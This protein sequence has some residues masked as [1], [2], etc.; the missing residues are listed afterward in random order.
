MANRRSMTVWGTMSPY[1][2]VV[3]VVNAQYRLTRYFCS[4]GSGFTSYNVVQE[5]C[6]K[7]SCKAVQRRSHPLHAHHAHQHCPRS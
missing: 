4:S 1:P 2:T 5:L 6:V 7:L 3:N